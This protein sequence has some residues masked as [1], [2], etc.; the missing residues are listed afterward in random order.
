MADTG[1]IRHTA[2]F[3]DGAFV[4]AE[5]GATLQ[6]IDPSTE[7]VLAE[8]SAAQPADVER[9]VA[10]A[11]AA[12]DDGRWSGLDA[13]ARARVLWRMADA[14]G[15]RREHL[16]HLES[17]DAGKTLF[18]SGKIEIPFAAEILRYYAGWA[19][20]LH[21]QTS[22]NK[23]GALLY[24]LREPVGVVG[25]IIPWN[26]PFLMAMWKVAPALAAGCSV[27]L[28]PA[29]LTPL[30]ALELAEIAREA[31]LP[32]GVLN[33]VPG[34]GQSAGRALV[35]ARGVDKVAFTGSTAV[36][37]EVMRGAA[38]TLKRVSLE[39]GGKSANIAFADADPERVAK[40]ALTGIFY[41]KGEVCAAGSRLLVER[42]IYD[43][44]VEAVAARA[45]K[46]TLGPA[47]DETTRMGPL[48]S[49][50]QLERVLG[51]IEKGKA[52][53][54]RL[55]CGGARDPK[56]GGG[57]G[58]FVQPT[59]FAEVA[60]EHTIA[61]E[62]IFGPV[63]SVIPFEGEDEAV[64]IANG[65]AYGLAAAVH[66]RDI[67]R[68]HRV[69][70]AL[71]AGTVWINTYNLYDPDLPFGGTGESGLGRELGAAALDLYTETKSVWVDLS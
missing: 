31:G 43:A 54:A 64:A 10:A 3:I 42:P 15:A 27:V 65:T 20:K 35:E 62:E 32:D 49:A 52:E 57:K 34:L 22:L 14:I 2:L 56:A 18:D 67:G 17:R 60:P 38:G 50:G 26:F 48:V 9:A 8:V 53:G 66:T 44:V 61:Q 28:K 46:L 5:G 47:L 40:V 1:A 71:K 4:E 36:G 41:N 55:C 19:T 21:G 12:F 39:L 63:L 37:R 58:F 29:E 13:S 25:A 69:A 16:A 33:V 45:Q 23:P 6:T 70:R 59:V 11:R 24:T 30:S 68:A 7:E 51:Y